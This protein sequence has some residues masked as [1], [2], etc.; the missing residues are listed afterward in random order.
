MFVPRKKLKLRNCMKMP[1][2]SRSWVALDWYLKNT[3]PT[4]ERVTAALSIPT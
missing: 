3:G 2:C 4:A 1:Y